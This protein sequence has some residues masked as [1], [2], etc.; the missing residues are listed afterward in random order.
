MRIFSRARDRSGNTFWRGVRRAK[1]IG[2]DSPVFGAKIRVYADF[3][4]G[5]L[6]RKTSQGAARLAFLRGHP[7]QAK[8][9]P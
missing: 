8:M 4:A 5:F 6:L 1:K 3:S 7:R 2:A 9:C